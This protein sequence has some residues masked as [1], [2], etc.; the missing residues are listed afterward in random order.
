M[1]ILRTNSDNKDF[2]FLV[3]LLDADLA[4]RDGSDHLYYAQFNKTDKI[5]YV[6]VAYQNNHPVGCGA[7]KEYN[8]ATMEIKRMYTLQ[9]LRG[10]GIASQILMELENWVMEL[11][12]LKTILETGKRQPEAIRV[13]EKNGYNLIPNYDQNAGMENSVC[14]EKVLK[15]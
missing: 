7:I 4:L 11:G 8:S 3:K 1:N 6:I 10:R 2:I 14:Y 13:Y 9:E 5:K 12:Y 15:Q